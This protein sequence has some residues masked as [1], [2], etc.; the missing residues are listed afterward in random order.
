[1]LTIV[2]A[3]WVHTDIGG[4]TVYVWRTI[5]ASCAVRVLEFVH[6]LQ[7]LRWLK[8]WDGCV[9]GKPLLA[10]AVLFYH[11]FG[12]KLWLSGRAAAT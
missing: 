7:V 9:F 4:D 11:E 3:G 1:M 6:L 2:R 10:I 12:V 8:E 5:V